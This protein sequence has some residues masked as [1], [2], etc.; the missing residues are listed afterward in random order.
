MD[1][2][3]WTTAQLRAVPNKETWCQWVLPWDF[4]TGNHNITCRATDGTGKLQTEQRAAP[5]PN[6][7]AGWHSVVAL[8][9]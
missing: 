5:R 4:T 2:G 6:G 1:D 9:G 8:V 3:P 7:A